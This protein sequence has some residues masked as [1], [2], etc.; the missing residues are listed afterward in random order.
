MQFR[1]LG[2]VE[3]TGPAG[4]IEIRAKKVRQLLSALLVRANDTI[5]PD[6]L[7][8]ALWGAHPPRTATKTL[9]TYV[10]QLRV[11]LHPDDRLVT[12]PGGY[13]LVVEPEEIDVVAFERDAA[14]GRAAMLRKDHGS[15]VRLLVR[16]LGMWRGRA[17]EELE[18][19]NFGV[20]ERARLESL[21]LS[22]TEDLMEAR[23]G[24]GADG[25]LAADLE[26]LVAEHPLRER[27][28][29]QLMHALY[30][31]GR[32]ADALRAY[33]NARATLVEQLGVEPGPE[34]RA[35]ERA[36]LDQD[37]ALDGQSAGRAAA[38]LP[39]IAYATT[40]DGLNIAF[41]SFG[42]G[43]LDLVFVPAA[44]SHLEA[45]W[46]D[47]ELAELYRRLGEFARVIVFD[48][49]GTG[50]SDPVSL[51]DPPTL[52]D[53]VDDVGAVMESAGSE[54]AALYGLADGGAVAALYA[55]SHPERVA[56]LVMYNS[57]AR[58]VVADDYPIGFAPHVYETFLETL[59]AHWGT[60][61]MVPFLTPHRIGDEEFCDRVARLERLSASPAL[62]VAVQRLA[63]AVDI[64]RVLKSVRVPTLVIADAALAAWMV[65][66]GRH[67]AN[68]IAGAQ[69]LEISAGGL[70]YT[71]PEAV[72]ALKEFVTAER[73]PVAA[74]RAL[75]SVVHVP[76][77]AVDRDA[78]TEEVSD[79]VHRQIARFNGTRRRHDS[80][81]AVALFDSPGRAVAC[82]SAVLDAARSR[83]VEA[84]VGVHV[85]DVPV[86]E[87][88]D[89]GDTGAL[90]RH[91]AGV[92][93]PSE[94]LVTSPVVD[95]MAGSRLAFEDRGEYDFG[96]KLRRC[97]LAA[98][99]RT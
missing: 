34:L 73:S 39:R 41:Q 79:V 52:A 66:F 61:I 65:P 45:S 84:R 96:D 55:A 87:P 6:D 7:F 15:G 80:A 62:A 76:R 74:T 33:Q 53:M 57:A 4:T 31:S 44:V 37:P 71:S 49:R 91:A 47:P 28:W 18:D 75:A 77:D 8:E 60:G 10:S 43:P 95:L 25:D 13:A 1:V 20:A 36:V 98:L 11:L 69:F 72:A 82:A 90:A 81:H 50:M 54:R 83:G 67:L 59:R 63:G 27:L 38:R 24:V 51:V 86:R 89:I 35:M 30:R 26:R 94:I 22:A 40:A 58:Y 19:S 42:E 68:N 56:S 88:D 85:G 64:R 16:A 2:P 92:A 14:A 32:Q 99:R 48:K 93:Q 3:V 29:A 78:L 70:G 5:A 46:D 17:H 23:L 97:R 12:R 9:H 21:R